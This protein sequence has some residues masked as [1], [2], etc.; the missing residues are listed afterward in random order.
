MSRTAFWKP[1]GTV[2]LIAAVLVLLPGTSEACKDKTGGFFDWERCWSGLRL[3]IMGAIVAPIS[4][5]IFFYLV[6]RQS[7]SYHKLLQ[8]PS[9][10][11]AFAF[12]FAGFW[13]LFWASFVVLFAFISDELRKP[14]Y[15]LMGTGGWFG[16]LVNDNWPWFVTS[17]CVI[18]STIVVHRYLRQRDVAAKSES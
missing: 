3:T 10:R 17:V 13:F 12:A 18:V 7:L 15:T 4:W 14:A 16:I 1:V 9:P 8:A 2:V 5:G 6:F 11:Q